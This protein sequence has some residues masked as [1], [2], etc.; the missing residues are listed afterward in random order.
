MF[1]IHFSGCDSQW[2]FSQRGTEI[3]H[4]TAL[5]LPSRSRYP[6]LLSCWFQPDQ[7]VLAARTAPASAQPLG[8]RWVL[9]ALWC[10]EAFGGGCTRVCILDK[11]FSH[12]EGKAEAV[13]GV[14]TR[15]TGHAESS[16][17]VLI[18]VSTHCWDSSWYWYRH[19]NLN[20]SKSSFIQPLS[21]PWG[22][23]WG[24]TLSSFLLNVNRLHCAS[25]QCKTAKYGS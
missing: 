2:A 24:Q 5:A 7:L 12:G 9:C 14:L 6:A 4:P 19:K 3:A 18:S 22:W 1:K 10:H 8:L 21:G 11:V 23:T 20:E 15:L 13:V 17:V 16:L 25:L